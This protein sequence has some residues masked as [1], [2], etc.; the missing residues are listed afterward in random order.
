MSDTVV[1]VDR[2]AEIART[3]GASP[4]RGFTHGRILRAIS[5][6]L[7]GGFRRDLAERL[8]ISTA[9]V[10]RAIALMTRPEVGLVEEGRHQPSGPGRPVAP[11][12]L[13]QN[14]AMIGIAVTAYR[15]MP[16]TLVGTVAYI[17]GTPVPG[18]E[19]PR[20]HP[21]EPAPRTKTADFVRELEK[22]ALSL[23][24]DSGLS[25][26]RRLLGCGITIAGYV[27]D[28]GELRGAYGGAWSSVQRPLAFHASLERELGI[29]V[30]V[31]ND[32]TSLAVRKNFRPSQPAASYA[33]MVAI[34]YG[35]GGAVVVKGRTWLGAHGMAGEP[36]H[37]PASA[38]GTI[39]RLPDDDPGTPDAP[40]LIMPS[41]QCETNAAT[42][43][44]QAELERQATKDDDQSRR[45]ERAGHVEAFASPHAIERRAEENAL[46]DS[47]RPT[48]ELAAHPRTDRG[49]SLLFYQGG[50]ALGRAVVSVINW[51]DPER[52]VIYLPSDT[53]HVTNRY[54]AGSYYLEGLEQ[55]IE[56]HAFAKTVVDKVVEI[57]GLS[58]ETIHERLASGAAYLVLR[59]LVLLI[60]GEEELP[61]GGSPK[62]GRKSKNDGDGDLTAAHPPGSS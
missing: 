48:A 56:K 42:L 45:P 58:N 30:V 33:L 2:A 11:L 60:N 37:L 12:R 46:V 8:N 21:L 19:T 35:V 52:V 62:F 43:P 54:L 53:L 23:K 1:W 6:H 36:G 17:D 3:L 27:D 50:L 28:R 29:P 38:A 47:Y 31:G 51:L 34:D 9:T 14:L 25:E 24:E 5:Q 61:G 44:E 59:R 4:I 13:T 39:M 26:S 22:F 18:F 16:G 7:G 41:C 10:T 15:G 20:Y 55:E 57:R 49:V 32:I 40:A